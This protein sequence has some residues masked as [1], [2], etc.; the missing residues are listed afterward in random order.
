MTVW[1]GKL[2]VQLMQLG[3]G[4]TKG[5]T[6]VWLPQEQMLFSGDLVEFGA[7]PYAGDAYFNDWPQTLDKRRGAR[8][9]RRSCPAA[10][11]ALTDAG[12]VPRRHRDDRAP[13]SPTVR[14]ASKRASR[15]GTDLNAVYDD[16]YAALRAEVRPAGSSS[17]TACRSTSR[18]PT[19]KRREHRDPRIWTAER[20]KAMWASLG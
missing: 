4:H 2:E 7:T 12:D 17:S 6:V 14:A 10:A 13:S 15:R 16:T 8:A 11:P 5:D 9:P 3:R 18:A 1:L 19:T 20:D